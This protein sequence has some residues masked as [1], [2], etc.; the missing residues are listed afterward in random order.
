M[1]LS[2]DPTR[3]LSVFAVKEKSK[4]IDAHITASS[5]SQARFE[6]SVGFEEGK[7]EREG[8]MGSRAPG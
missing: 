8:Q 4:P 3:N 7:R 2:F 5:K 6:P 1:V